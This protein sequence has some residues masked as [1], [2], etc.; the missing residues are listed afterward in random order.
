MVNKIM[1]SKLFHIIAASM[2]AASALTSCS[3]DDDAAFVLRSDDNLKFS[4][5]QE[6]KDFTVC[7]N[8]QWTIT[9]D[10]SWLSFST[11][12]GTGDGSTR[13][14]IL[15]TA[16]RNISEARRDS[17]IL[18][19]AG[20][21]LT[22]I[23]QQEEGAPLSLGQASLSG[24]LQAGIAADGV[25]INVPYTYGYKGQELTLQATLSG[26]GAEGLTVS[27][28]T[29]TLDAAS[30]TLS[31]PI[32]GTPTTSGALVIKIVTNDATANTTVLQANVLSK[33]LLDQHFD[34]MLW[35]SDIVNYKKGIKGSFVKDAS[36][37]YVIDET[38]A[39][40]ECSATADGS[41]DLILSMAE[42]YR[43]LRGFSGWGGERIYEHPGYVKVGTGTKAG[44]IITPALTDLTNGVTTVKVT[45]RVNQY[46]SEKNGQLT[47]EVLGGGTP[48]ISSY[49]Y[50]YE[51]NNK[52]TKGTWEDV[53]FTIDGV[54]SATQVKFSTKGN[55]R[56]CID[57]IV[58]SEG[59]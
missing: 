5:S 8:G 3:S 4:Y 49:T 43:K 34:L 30:G 29:F 38:K 58:I 27:E 41:N 56:F 32:S 48:S 28:R 35:G 33:L 6:D 16:A 20:K 22:V 45:C 11:T 12:S 31:L 14:K 53:S 7:T 59:K 46:Y 37:K 2:V 24:S 40:A 39:V 26:A 51:G 52:N 13:E 47:I 21:D 1:K 10:C 18:H 44:W 15:V 23:C 9:S 54:N 25:S 36:G 57:D 55:L 17:F 19:A 50:K 42:S